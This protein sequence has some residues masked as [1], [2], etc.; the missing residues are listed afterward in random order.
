MIMTNL[1][2]TQSAEMW[3]LISKGGL[4]DIEADRPLEQLGGMSPMEFV[5]QVATKILAANACEPKSRSAQITIAAGL[6]GTM[7]DLEM[8]I[9]RAISV[10]SDFHDGVTIVESQVKLSKDAIRVAVRLVQSFLGYD[11]T[12]NPDPKMYEERARQVRE[13]LKSKRI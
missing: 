3:E 7:P 6:G 9:R 1:T 2:R 13:F 10:L 8:E 5:E 12:K 4:R 11:E